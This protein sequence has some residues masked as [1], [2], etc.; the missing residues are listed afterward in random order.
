[1]STT[2]VEPGPVDPNITQAI[3]TPSTTA[4]P[5]PTTTI[6]TEATTTYNVTNATSTPMNYDPTKVPPGGT[7]YNVKCSF[8]SN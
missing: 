5:P 4:A 8:K 2:T 7:K 3:T 1:M 6:T